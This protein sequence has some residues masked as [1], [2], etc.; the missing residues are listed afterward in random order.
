MRVARDP[1]WFLTDALSPI[2]T[3]CQM[4]L[5]TSVWGCQKRAGVYYYYLKRAEGA[6]RDV[7]VNRGQQVAAHRGSAPCVC[8]HGLS[9][10]GL[11]Q[12]GFIKVHF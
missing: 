3:V 1:S 11:P 6:E 4:F 9:C 12:R 8:A 5:L 2:I 10:T 7:A